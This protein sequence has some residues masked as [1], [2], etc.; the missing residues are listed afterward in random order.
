MPNLESLINDVRKLD[1]EAADYLEN[2]A[3][4]LGSYDDNKGEGDELSAL[5]IWSESPQGTR[6]WANLDDILYDQDNEVKNNY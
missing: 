1:T 6:Y 2:G 3:P 4:K 5:F